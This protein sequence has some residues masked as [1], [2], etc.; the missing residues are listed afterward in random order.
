MKVGI[1][2]CIVDTDLIDLKIQKQILVSLRY[3][4]EEANYN[5]IN[6]FNIIKFGKDK[7]KVFKIGN[8]INNYHYTN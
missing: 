1:I 3:F 6:I 5:I 4:I 7:I 8:T 2:D